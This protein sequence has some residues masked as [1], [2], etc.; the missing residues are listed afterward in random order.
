MSDAVTSWRA[1]KILPHYHVFDK[2]ARVIYTYLTAG[3]TRI[4][5][6]EIRRAGGDPRVTMAPCHCTD[7]L[8]VHLFR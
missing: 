6:Q 1:G 3:K 4:K 2:K 8:P 7:P 5:A